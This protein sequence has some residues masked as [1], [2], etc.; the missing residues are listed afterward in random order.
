MSSEVKRVLVTGAGG[1]IGFH[2]VDYLKSQGYWVRG[3]DIKSPEYKDSSADEFMQLDLRDYRN[4]VSACRDVDWV[5]HLAA[6]MGGIGYI[7]KNHADV[8]RNNTLMNLS[9]LEASDAQKV[10]RFI[11]S[12]TACVYPMWMQ[13]SPEIKPLKEEDAY[14]AEPEEGYGWEK[15]YME[16]LCEYYRQDH[17]LDTRIV[18]FHN[19]YGPLGS[20]CGGREKAPA[21]VCRK[22]AEAEDGNTIE[23]WGDGQQSRS[24]MYVSDCVEG[25]LKIMKSEYPIPFNLG[26]EDLIT[27]DDLYDLVANIAGKKIVKKHDISKPQGVRG[28][29]SD[30]TQIKNLLN[31]EPSVTMSEGLKE[32]Y[33]WIAKQVELNSR[34]IEMFTEA[35]SLA[36][37]ASIAVVSVAGEKEVENNKARE[38]GV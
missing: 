21:A 24:F 2:L 13:K 38:L 22:I 28:R 18:R 8:C 26:R 11:F 30:N 3:V 17:G 32:T 5:F 29:N 15:L 16:K 1:F 9:M 4:C 34:K 12:S 33:S 31:W 20:W 10:K 25:V 27:I 35:A 19:V 37:D 6:D 36:V 14:P 7:S 23:I